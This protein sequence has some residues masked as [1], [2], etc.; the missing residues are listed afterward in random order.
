M[1]IH[2]RIIGVG[3]RSI[4]VACTAC[5]EKL[6]VQVSAWALSVKGGGGV[7][8]GRQLLEV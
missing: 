8:L 6:H 5:F 2:Q 1:Y 3:Q 4:L 7:M